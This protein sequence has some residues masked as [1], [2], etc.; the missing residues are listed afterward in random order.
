MASSIKG[1]LKHPTDLAARDGGEEFALLLLHTSLEDA[2]L[3]AEEIRRSVKALP[4]L[5]QSSAVSDRITISLGVA[6]I[7]PDTQ[8]LYPD[9][10]LHAANKALYQAKAEGRDQVSVDLS[11]V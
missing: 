3:I 7:T 1:C 4:I 11:L 10:L 9:L 2:I 5:H 8:S 6:C